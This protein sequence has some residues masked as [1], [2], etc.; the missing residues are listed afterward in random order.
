MGHDEAER[1]RAPLHTIIDA[2]S[3]R[4][5][6]R[7]RGSNVI[8]AAVFAVLVAITSVGGLLTTSTSASATTPPATATVAASPTTTTPIAEPPATV[9]PATEEP[10]PPNAPSSPTTTTTSTGLPPPAALRGVPPVGPSSAIQPWQRTYVS[11]TEPGPE[12][13]HD[14]MIAA[15]EWSNHRGVDN[16]PVTGK[17]KI[18]LLGDSVD[19]QLRVS[20]IFDPM[21]RWSVATHCGENYATSLDFGR[22]DAV[23]A[24][25][26]DILVSGSGANNISYLWTPFEELLATFQSSFERYLNHTDQ[27]KCRVVFTTPER[28]SPDATFE[29]A[30]VWQSLIQR[31]NNTIRTIDPNVHPNVFVVDWAA[32]TA[33]F[34]GLLIDD[35]HLSNAGI[36]TRINLILSTSRRCYV[37]NAP[38]QVAAASGPSSATV[39][40]PPSIPEEGVS[41]YAVQ[42]STGQVRTLT[43]PALGSAVTPSVTF[44]GLPNGVAVAFT[45]TA[46]NLGGTSSPSAPSAIVTP[47]AMGS[48]FRPRSPVRVLDTRDGTGGRVGPVGPA[49]AITLTI[50]TNI[51]VPNEADAYVLN[52]T[53]T[54]HTAASFVTVWPGGQPR[55]L[56]SNLNP[57]P[58][59]AA[60]PALVTVRAGPNRTLH[61]YNNSGSLHLVAD[62]LGWYDKA[63]LSAG[64]LFLPLPTQRVLDTRDGTG[65]RATSLG[66]GESFDLD[67]TSA[68]AATTGASA[69]IVNLTAASATSTGFLTLWPSGANRP[70]ASSLNPQ[71]GRARS[72]LAIV[73]VG[74]NGKVSVYNNSGA[75]H[76][77]VD[78]VGVFGAAGAA[79]GGSEYVPSPPLRLLDTRD[80]TGGLPGPVGNSE[81]S[82]VPLALT[83][84]VPSDAIA[85]DANLT[86]VAPSSSG[87]SVAWPGGA[88]PPTASVNFIAGETIA[89]R[90]VTG[91]AS[92]TVSLWSTPSTIHY[93]LDVSG[94]FGPLLGPSGPITPMGSAQPGQLAGRLRHAGGIREVGNRPRRER[95]D[96]ARAGTQHGSVSDRRAGQR[97]VHHV[98]QRGFRPVAS[99]GTRWDAGDRGRPARRPLSN[100]ASRTPDH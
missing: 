44:T 32:A 5:D 59:L 71:P 22:T 10:P 99:P 27:V 49:Q 39:W 3:I 17:P 92:G 82:I 42:A 77:L 86:V 46:T 37:P 53:A 43:A 9:P 69:V 11:T 12:A 2:V 7:R 40:W 80:G 60:V 16:T 51:G 13:S 54:D 50:P 66:A 21:F 30:A 93:V 4:P 94:W 8:R 100:A 83:G 89:N 58:G 14:T 90:I 33:F 47:A 95:V 76:V 1:R 18:G 52:V 57:R 25:Q 75:T 61:L 29:Q 96:H 38:Q 81:P 56:V 85:I 78:L 97:Q 87:H 73:P 62:L 41:S 23:L 64:A 88:L 36:N 79:T 67:L 68:T 6:H 35:Q 65:G 20:A 70:L 91:V 55:P 72:N 31:M 24:E 45:V 15:C 19:N 98:R 48:R 74:A 63:G 26:P 84:L 28:W 34:P